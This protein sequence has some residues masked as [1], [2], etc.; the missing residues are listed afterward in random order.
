MI[1]GNDLSKGFWAEAVSTACHI[2]N[3][4]YAKPGKK[5]TPYQIWKGKSPNLSHFRVF[6][7]VCYI[8]NDKEQLG[9]F[10]SRSD[11]GIFLGYSTNSSAYR[12][13]NKRTK[14]I[15]DSVNVVFDDKARFVLPP[16]SDERPVKAA[17]KPVETPVTPVA[18]ETENEQPDDQEETVEPHTPIVTSASKDLTVHRNHKVDDVIFDLNTRTTR[19]VQID[20]HEML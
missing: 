13:Y 11:E 18:E 1:H 17:S 6:G 3:R 8:L 19:G 9:K 12:V 20:F 14:T 16:V 5:T 2:I 10:A 4:V 7:C 15:S